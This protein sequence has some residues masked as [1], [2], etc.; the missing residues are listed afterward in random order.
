MREIERIRQLLDSHGIRPNRALGQNFLTDEDTLERIADLARVDGCAVLEIGPGLGSLTE[1]LLRRATRVEAV[2]K[3]AVLADILRERFPGTQ[4]GITAADILRTDPGRLLP[5]PWHAVGNLPYYITTDIAE[6]MLC[7]S[8]ESA[9]FLVQK[10]AAERFFAGPGDRVYG[11][12]S[13]LTA[14]VSRPERGFDVPACMFYPQPEVEST[15]IRLAPAG[16]VPGTD[17]PAGF[18]RFLKQCFRMRRKT[19]ANNLKG[20]AG[21]AEAMEAA[22][23]D[24]G[25][26]A[27]ALPPESLLA[28]YLEARKIR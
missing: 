23:V 6:R 4:P 19:L 9:T 20:T 11:P 18:L 5:R 28:L 25:I 2:E 27:E 21:A 8:P 13:V 15:V 14:C 10:E 16:D 26:R 12:L 22:G 17:D 7:F 3:D 1:R 24:G